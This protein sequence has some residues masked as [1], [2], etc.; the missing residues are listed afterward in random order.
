[1]LLYM[2]GI[3]ACLHGILSIS[4]LFHLFRKS[5]SSSKFDLSNAL[6]FAIGSVLS[7][8]MEVDSTCMLL[9]VGQLFYTEKWAH[10]IL[11]ISYFSLVDNTHNPFQADSPMHHSNCIFVI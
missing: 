11:T 4:R 2:Y 8:V 3:G 9:T 10:Y 1:M 6:D 5:Y 7:Y